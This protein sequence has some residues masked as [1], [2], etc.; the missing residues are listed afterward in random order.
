VPF[1]EAASVIISADA[2]AKASVTVLG[3]GGGIRLNQEFVWTSIQPCSAAHSTPRAPRPSIETRRA[4]FANEVNLP[5]ERDA[6]I[7]PWP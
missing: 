2:L 1:P 3:T 4:S 6:V 5:V 7:V